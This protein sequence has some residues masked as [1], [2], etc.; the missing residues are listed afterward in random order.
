[1]SIYMGNEEQ[2]SSEELIQIEN[3]IDIMIERG[4]IDPSQK[5]YF[6]N[7]LVN[8]KSKEQKKGLKRDPSSSG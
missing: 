6:F 7:K 1:M 4:Y 3:Q 8:E 5:E 2:I